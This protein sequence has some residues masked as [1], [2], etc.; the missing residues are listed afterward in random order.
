MATCAAPVVTIKWAAMAR[1]ALLFA[2]LSS[3]LLTGQ[4]KEGEFI[5]VDTRTCAYVERV[6]QE[7]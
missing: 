7:R 6:K 3:R 1:S 2:L 4:V 5:R